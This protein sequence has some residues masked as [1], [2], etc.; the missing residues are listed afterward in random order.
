MLTMKAKL[1]IADGQLDEAMALAR[2]T[3]TLSKRM[4]EDELL[5]EALV[6]IAISSQLRTT[7]FH[8]WISAPNSPN[9]YWAVN[10]IPNY[11]DTSRIV[12]TEFDMAEYTFHELSNLDKQPLTT[13]EANNLAYRVWNV[14]RFVEPGRKADVQGRT[15]LLLWV[16]RSYG[17]ACRDLEK[18]GYSIERLDAMPV[19]Q[20]ALIVPLAALPTVT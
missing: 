16:T 7:F 11:F 8:D 3:F 20:V 5:V 19:T 13:E 4:Q 15:G 14:E 9:L 12:A 1:H 18:Q 10:T 2:D 17:E 6:G